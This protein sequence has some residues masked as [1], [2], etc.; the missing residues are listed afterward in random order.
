M[1][2]FSAP[3]SSNILGM[4]WE[5]KAWKR[6]QQLAAQ[7]P[8]EWKIPVSLQSKS[9]VDVRDIPLMSGILDPLDVEITQSSSCKI[10]DEIR[11]SQWSCERVM[12]AFCKR[13][14]IAHQLVNCVTNFLTEEALETAREHDRYF[15]DTGQV[16]GPLHGLPISVK[17]SFS[18]GIVILAGLN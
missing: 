13:A 12:L 11:K 3:I 16:K 9:L 5:T 7:I 6:R 18:R 15:T 17:V 10:L 14:V 8:E 2:R 1:A 4:E